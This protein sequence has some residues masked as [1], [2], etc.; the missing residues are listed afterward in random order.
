MK[1]RI[2]AALAALLALL[3]LLAPAYALDERQNGDGS[4]SGIR[5]IDGDEV[6]RLG[7]YA[8]NVATASG[9]A[10]N[11]PAYD[12]GQTLRFNVPGAN[13]TGGGG[14]LSWTNNLG[15]D[16]VVVAHVLNVST[17]STGAA[18][19]S[20]GGTN[21][22]AT[23]SSTNMISSQAVGSTGT[24]NG[25]ALSIL[26]ANGKFIT[27]TGSADTTGLIAQAIFSFVKLPT[28]GSVLQKSGR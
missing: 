8:T 15:Y 18:N 28:V 20:C 10:V 23:T 24:F 19:V 21:T 27:C 13:N 17:A 25:G 1:T 3:V 5:E 4:M 22:N 26:V 6:Y 9:A 11:T 16:I 14:L 12:G 7:G 2:S